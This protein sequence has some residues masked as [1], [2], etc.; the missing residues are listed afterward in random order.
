M[1][2]MVAFAFRVV[3]LVVILDFGEN[4]SHFLLQSVRFFHGLQNLFA[5]QLVHGR[6][7]DNSVLI[8]LPDQADAVFN[9][10]LAGDIGPAQNNRGGMLN[11]VDKEFAEILEVN[12]AF[13]GIHNS[14]QSADLTVFTADSA[15]RTHYIA[16]LADA[17]GLDQDPVGMIGIEHFPQSLAEIAHQA[18]ANAAAVHFGDLDTGFLHEAAVNADFSEFV[19][20]QHDLLAGIGILQQL[21]D[22]GCLSGSKESGE[23]INLSHGKI[24]PFSTYPFAV[25]Y[26]TPSRRSGQAFYLSRFSV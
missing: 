19:F 14:Y 5:I 2:M 8:M 16:Q 23:H 21:L 15:G 24:T 26:C 3:A 11:L 20:D 12:L 9:F 7:D 18:A 25:G 22:Q 4:L 17:A 10:L 13:A 6:G 1:V